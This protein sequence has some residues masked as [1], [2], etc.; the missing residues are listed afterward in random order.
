M[1]YCKNEDDI[2]RSKHY[3]I[4]VHLIKND[5]F[6]GHHVVILI[7][8]LTCMFYFLGICHDQSSDIELVT[9]GVNHTFD[10]P[11]YIISECTEVI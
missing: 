10:G 6:A 4:W 2:S 1:S 9:F 7:V 5:L 8:K 3:L 11:I